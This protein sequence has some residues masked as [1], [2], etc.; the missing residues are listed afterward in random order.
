MSTIWMSTR[1]CEGG[2]R[3][4]RDS[5]SARWR[6]S[7]STDCLDRVQGLDGSLVGVEGLYKAMA[8]GGQ[9][10][11]ELSVSC[12]FRVALGKIQD[13]KGRAQLV[14]DDLQVLPNVRRVGRRAAG[15]DLHA[16]RFLRHEDS[17]RP[18]PARMCQRRQPVSIRR[19]CAA[20]AAWIP[21]ANGIRGGFGEQVLD[22]PL[23][24]YGSS[25]TERS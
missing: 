17:E 19:R 8:Q 10:V 20:G 3:I 25:L 15:G 1:R 13:A 21:K 6:G 22:A 7:L 9:G 23:P 14:A 4:R 11:G 12:G 24:P 16:A 5:F 18:P 2:K